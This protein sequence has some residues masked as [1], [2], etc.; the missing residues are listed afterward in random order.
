MSEETR[1]EI[2]QNGRLVLGWIAKD[3]VAYFATGDRRTP[4]QVMDKVKEDIEKYKLE[5]RVL[6][7]KSEGAHV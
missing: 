7:D 6:I 5:V 2:D 1:E 4:I 3:I